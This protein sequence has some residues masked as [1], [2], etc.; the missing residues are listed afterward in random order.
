MKNIYKLVIKVKGLKRYG[1]S[2]LIGNSQ[3]NRYKWIDKHLNVYW[4]SCGGIE[5]QMKVRQHQFLSIILPKLVRII[6]TVNENIKG[7]HIICCS[8]LYICMH[9]LLDI[10]VS[11]LLIYG[12]IGVCP[13]IRNAE[14][15]TSSPKG[16]CL[17]KLATYLVWKII[18]IL[19]I[20]SSV[21]MYWIVGYLCYEVRK[22]VT[23]MCTYHVPFL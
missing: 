6:S 10:V 19:H 11:F 7:E 8:L 15:N 4:F 17:N 16:K 20:L 18:H 3:R 1:Q 9:S 12:H 22:E 13:M 23:Q 2:I 21:H 14:Q 5:K